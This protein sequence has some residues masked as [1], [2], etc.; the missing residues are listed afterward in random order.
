L[1]GRAGEEKKKERRMS[2]DGMKEVMTVTSLY[3]LNTSA[4][5]YIH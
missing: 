3:L 2:F 1:D 5:S 4:T